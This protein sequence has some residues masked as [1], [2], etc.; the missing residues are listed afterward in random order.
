MEYYSYV[1]YSAS[2]NI[3]YKGST[4]DISKRVIEHNLGKVN[5]TSKYLPWELILFERHETRSLA[6][7][8]EKWYKTGVGREWIELQV[9]ES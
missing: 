9:K 4:S 5:F 3:Y 6:L 8:R 1:L 7:K 2:K